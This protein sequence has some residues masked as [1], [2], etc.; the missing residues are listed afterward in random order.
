MAY[1]SPK[2]RRTMELLECMP[3]E[4]LQ[5]IMV[6]LDDNDLV[7]FMVSNKYVKSVSDDDHFWKWVNACSQFCFLRY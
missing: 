2:T 4:M 3:R 6:E 7:N 1:R 5:T